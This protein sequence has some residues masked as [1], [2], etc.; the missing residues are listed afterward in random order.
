VKWDQLLSWPIELKAL[1][2]AGVVFGVIL[3]LKLVFRRFKKV[4][5]ADPQFYRVV[6]SIFARKT[7]AFFAVFLSLYVGASVFFG[8]KA[9]H[10]GAH[11]FFFAVCVFQ[12]WIWARAFIEIFFERRTLQLSQGDISKATSF[13]AIA[14]VANLALVIILVLFTLDNFG[15]NISALVAGLGVGGIAI[16][17]AVQNILG[18]L[19]ASI[20]ILLDKPFVVGDMVTV[21]DF[22]GTIENIGIKTTRVR[23]VSGEQVIFSNADL[24]QSRIRNFKRLY[25]RRVVF[26]FGLTYETPLDLIEKIPSIVK[27]IITNTEDLRFERAH[28][29]GFGASS[30]DFEVVYFV[31]QSDYTIY[32]DR[33]Q[34][35]NLAVARRF[36]SL[37]VDFAYPTSTLKVQVASETRQA[38]R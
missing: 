14:F 16:A 2:V 1:V 33:Q 9:W 25:E 35:V 34:S 23:S 13:R 4:S 36:S 26:C 17:L 8:D 11:R 30:L 15:V 5:P 20:T 27:E 12:V 32:M 38:P 7:G 22:S 24:L 31:T 3:F 37:N 10:L 18:D 19:F 29:K 28:F 6:L 21:G